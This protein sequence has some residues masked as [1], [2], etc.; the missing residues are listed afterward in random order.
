VGF[1]FATAG[2]WEGKGSQLVGLRWYNH[3]LDRFTFVFRETNHLWV[4]D[5]RFCS[6]LNRGFGSHS[7]LAGRDPGEGEASAL[8]VARTPHVLSFAKMLS[9]LNAFEISNIQK[10]ETE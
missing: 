5:G 8:I 4:G 7:V 6:F 3:Q 1:C 10:Q 9:S 2:Q